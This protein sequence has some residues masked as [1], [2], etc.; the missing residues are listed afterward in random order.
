MTGEPGRGEQLLRTMG[1][2]RIA[3]F[4]LD[5]TLYDDTHYHRAAD[6]GIARHIALTAGLPFTTAAAAL[7]RAQEQGGRVRYLDRV[8]DLLA[9]PRS[10]ITG[11]LCILRTVDVRLT[12]YPWVGPL[13]ADLTARG[14]ARYVLTNGNRQQQQNKV[15]SLG[16]DDLPVQ[17]IY[18]SDH[19]SKPDP[20]G[21][22]HI[23]NLEGA[24]P[25]D[26]VL[27]GNDRT[28]ELCALACG[29]AYIDVR[30]VAG[31]F[32]PTTPRTR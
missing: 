5:G 3:V 12:F 2:P 21:L 1:E 10:A 24:T 6:L 15:R 18:A 14:C 7:A 11:M 19:R 22:R 31:C 4:D 13:F 29:A 25:R 17:V 27:V 20:A 9:L 23:I 32:S 30:R 28:D 8:C 16:L 26:A